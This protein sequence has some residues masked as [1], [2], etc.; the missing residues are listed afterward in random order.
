MYKIKSFLLIIILAASSIVFAENQEIE[1]PALSSIRGAVMGYTTT[2][3]GQLIAISNSALYHNQKYWTVSVIIGSNA[4]QKFALM[5]A[6]ATIASV[7]FQ[8]NTIAQ[9]IDNHDGTYTY[10]C[11]YD[12]NDPQ[13]RSNTVMLIA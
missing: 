9:A 5:D 2:F 7:A 13:Y 1:C 6:Q 8:Q 10:Y 4:R 3:K 11:Y 12:S